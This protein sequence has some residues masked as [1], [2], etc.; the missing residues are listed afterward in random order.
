MQYSLI[1]SFVK[2][3]EV[4]VTAN[5]E[6]EPH[7]LNGFARTEIV[8]FNKNGDRIQSYFLYT[9]RYDSIDEIPWEIKNKGF[10]RF[11]VERKIAMRYKQGELLQINSKYIEDATKCSGIEVHVRRNKKHNKMLSSSVD[12][13]WHNSVFIDRNSCLSVDEILSLCRQYSPYGEKIYIEEVIYDDFPQLD[14]EWGSSCS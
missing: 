9:K 13:I 3:Y 4:H 1:N 8:N 12:G 14:W 11:K 7:S 5:V 6:N 10:T 2:Q